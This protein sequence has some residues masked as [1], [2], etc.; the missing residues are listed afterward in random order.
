VDRPHFVY[1]F[2][3]DKYLDYF[4]SLAIMNSPI[5]AFVY[6]EA[7]IFPFGRAVPIVTRYQTF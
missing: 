4:S 2:R 7:D 6:N 1:L 5:Q 3:V